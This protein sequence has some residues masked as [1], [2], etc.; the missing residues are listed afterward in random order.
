MPTAL[1]M[2]W[3]SR[4][5]IPNMRHIVMSFS[6]SDRLPALFFHTSQLSS[7]LDACL[8]PNAS[9]SPIS[10]RLQPLSRFR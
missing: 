7:V 5:G 10:T 4:S 8:S 9:L 6:S 1:L 2:S 3:M